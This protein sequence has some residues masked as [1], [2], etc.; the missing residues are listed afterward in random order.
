MRKISC[1]CFTFLSSF[2]HH[3]N[4]E[5]TVGLNLS[6]DLSLI[7]DHL[8]FIVSSSD[9]FKELLLSDLCILFYSN[10]I[11][12]NFS[13]TKDILSFVFLSETFYVQ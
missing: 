13:R 4:F 3:N 2:A 1:F 7:K 8:Q 6:V 11:Y 5:E 9:F 12:E 10:I